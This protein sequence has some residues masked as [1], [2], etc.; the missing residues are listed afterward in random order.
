MLPDI[1]ERKHMVKTNIHA[2]ELDWFV[3]V[4][5]NR[6]GKSICQI[7]CGFGRSIISFNKHFTVLVSLFCGLV[8]EFF[9]N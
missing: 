5:S 8:T 1:A 4:V 6:E 9:D 3:S 2:R 7:S